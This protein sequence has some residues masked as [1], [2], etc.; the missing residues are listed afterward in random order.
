MHAVIY[1]L[2]LHAYQHLG[3][4]LVSIVVHDPARRTLTSEAVLKKSV[5]IEVD[6]HDLDPDKWVRD[7][8]VRAAELL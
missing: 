7:V 1:D 3:G 2:H 5:S 6:E 4:T 8:L